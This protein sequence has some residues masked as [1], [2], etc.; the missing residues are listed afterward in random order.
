MSTSSRE[1]QG[2]SVPRP[3]TN[4]MVA[5]APQVGTAKGKKGTWNF[6]AKLKLG[7]KK[8]EELSPLQWTSGAR[9]KTGRE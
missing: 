2:R 7:I 6:K 3:H 1:G 9:E 8:E 5:E 4:A